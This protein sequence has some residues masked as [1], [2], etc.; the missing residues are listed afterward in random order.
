VL[1]RA[2]TCWER[3]LSLVDCYARV[4]TMRCVP[5]QLLRSLVRWVTIIPL[6]VFMGWYWASTAAAI[7][8]ATAGIMAVVCHIALLT[9]LDVASSLEDP[10]DDAALD[11]LSCAEAVGSTRLASAALW[12]G[13]A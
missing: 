11:A 7:N 1:H 3:N 5:W 13:C 2:D 10:F 8:P 12:R 9:L 6:P 4:P